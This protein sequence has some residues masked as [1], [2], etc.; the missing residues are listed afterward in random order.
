MSLLIPTKTDWLDAH[1]AQGAEELYQQQLANLKEQNPE[2][3]KWDFEVVPGFF[4][5]LDPSTDDLEFRYTEANLGRLKLWKDIES[6]LQQLNDNSD[7]NVSYKLILCARHGQGFHNV[8]VE[9]YSLEEWHA[10]WGALGTDG[11]LDYGPDAM[12]TDLGINQGK[13]NRQVWAREI[14]EHG[15]PIPLKFYVSPLQRSLWTC[16]YTWEGLRPNHIKPVV[17]ESLRETIGRDMC[18]QRLL[19]SVILERF[20]KH[21]FVFEPGF[22]EED[23]FHG[24]FQETAMDHAVRTNKFCQALFEED[25]DEEL[26]KVNK[27]EARK[28]SFVATTSHA[29]TIR[30]FILVFGHRRFTVSTGGMVPIVVKATRRV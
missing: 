9:K 11:E 19:K 17:T 7:D 15:A 14:E 16:V 25:W 1:G 23:M 22:E 30:S 8:V 12:L 3:F 6:E 2:D 27:N 29:G 10:K 5:Q 13:E 4:A 18:N 26:G 24:K 28:H 20:G 21:D